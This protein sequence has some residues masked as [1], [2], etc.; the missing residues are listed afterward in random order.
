MIKET[1]TYMKVFVKAILGVSLKSL[2]M[3]FVVN[4]T[5]LRLGIHPMENSCTLLVNVLLL[6]K[7]I[8]KTEIYTSQLGTKLRKNGAMFSDFQKPSIP[9]TMK[10]EFLF[11]LMGK[12]FIS[13]QKDITLWVDTMSLKL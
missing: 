2:T 8:L 7:E 5:K 9:I 13:L 12:L 3:L 11:I 6:R 4:T 10:M 1:V